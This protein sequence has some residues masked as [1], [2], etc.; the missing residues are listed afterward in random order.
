AEKDIWEVFRRIVEQRKKKELEPIIKL[1]D[2]VTSVQE[3]CDA[4]KEFCKVVRELKVLSCQADSVLNKITNADQSWITKGI[5][6]V[7]K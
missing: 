3:E 4:S 6:N 2:D 5:L 1:F 7:F